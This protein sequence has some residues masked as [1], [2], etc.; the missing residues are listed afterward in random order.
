MF[1]VRT[2]KNLCYCLYPCQSIRTNRMIKLIIN[3]CYNEFS[4]ALFSDT[5]GKLL[6]VISNSFDKEIS[7]MYCNMY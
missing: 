3:K 6:C 7:Y 5:F 1:D 2:F 4:C